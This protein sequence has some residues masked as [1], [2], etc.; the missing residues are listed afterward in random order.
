MSNFLGLLSFLRYR[1]DHSALLVIGE[2]C[3]NKKAHCLRKRLIIFYCKGV[4]KDVKRG[5]WDY[6][7][8]LWFLYSIGI[9]PVDTCWPKEFFILKKNDYK[10]DCM[11]LKKKISEL[12]EERIVFIL[13]E[14]VWLYAYFLKNGEMEPNFATTFKFRII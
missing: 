1:K 9:F 5:T 4:F 14:M 10:V 12:W 2:N 8:R 6:R 13:R 3:W 11:L 7:S